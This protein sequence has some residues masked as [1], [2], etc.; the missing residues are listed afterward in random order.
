MQPTFLPWQGFFELMCYS[1]KFVILDD[2]QLSVQSYQTRNKLFV[3]PG[4]V[5]FYSVP[6][7]KAICFKNAI[8]QVL[9]VNENHW[10]EKILRRLKNNYSKSFYF[11]E[12]MPQ[13]EMWLMRNYMNLAEL[14]IGFILMVCEM[15]EIKVEILYSSNFTRECP[16]VAGRS[17]R[18]L[19]ILRWANADIYLCA[20]G[21]FD[22]MLEDGVFPVT[23][24][25]VFFQNFVPGPYR[26]IGVKTFVSHLSVLDALLN[27]G[28]KETRQLVESG[29]VRW[30]SWD[31]R[32][33]QIVL[34][35]SN[36]VCRSGL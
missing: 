1:N 35:D 12:I 36:G 29:T 23:H 31:E 24:P 14:N 4:R 11:S 28:P 26:Q 7:Q 30:L 15:L 2:F 17:Q 22:Y 19:E 21:S 32:K 8:N 6:I 9:I 16:S 5:D 27:V 13:I 20:S 34:P 3:S 33:A 18:V 25:E 10:K